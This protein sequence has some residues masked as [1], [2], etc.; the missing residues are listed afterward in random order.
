MSI[1]VRCI[2]IHILLELGKIRIS[3]IHRK[4]R[5]PVNCS[6]IRPCCINLFGLFWS[7]L[8]CYFTIFRTRNPCSTNYP[9]WCIH[10]D[11]NAD[12]VGVVREEIKV[13]NWWKRMA[14]LIFCWP[15]WFYSKANKLLFRMVVIV[16]DFTLCIP[17]F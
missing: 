8:L 4:L 11:G 1:R 6:R 16:Y 12:L 7:Y 17:F 15:P 9:S 5:S 2:L 3:K 13:Q 10:E 14:V